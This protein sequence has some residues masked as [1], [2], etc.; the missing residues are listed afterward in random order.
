MMFQKRG[1]VMA[2]LERGKRRGKKTAQTGSLNHY[3]NELY[4]FSIGLHL[5]LS[6]LILF[7]Q[8]M[9]VHLF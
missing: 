5:L 1:A 4:G 7:M 9:V 2:E 3:S 8:K 6:F